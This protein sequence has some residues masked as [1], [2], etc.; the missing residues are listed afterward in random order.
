MSLEMERKNR[1]Y[2]YGRLLAVA[3]KIESIALSVMDEKRPTAS[4]RYMLRFSQR[5]YSTWKIIHDSLV[6]YFER[7]RKNMVG[8]IWSLIES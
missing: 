1:D 8:H 5:P 7:I 6:P 3:E 4:E 2:L